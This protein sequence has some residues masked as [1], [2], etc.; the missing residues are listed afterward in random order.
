MILTNEDY[1]GL[2]QVLDILNRIVKN[3]VMSEL[4]EEHE[5]KFEKL[6]LSEGEGILKFSDKELKKMPKEIKE[7]LNRNLGRNIRQKTNGVYEIRLTYKGTPFYG[8][9]KD[10]NEAK[11]QFIESILNTQAPTEVKHKMKDCYVGL[12]LPLS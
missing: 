6:N 1:N 10:F 3:A 9:S 2:T 4:E 5:R 12:R 8:C 7:I 11:R